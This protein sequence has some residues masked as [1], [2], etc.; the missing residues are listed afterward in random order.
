MTKKVFLFIMATLFFISCS[1]DEESSK[2]HR[3]EVFAKKI[4][5]NNVSQAEIE[6]FILSDLEASKSSKKIDLFVD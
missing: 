5:E 2:S 1:K 6:S 4:F 3:M